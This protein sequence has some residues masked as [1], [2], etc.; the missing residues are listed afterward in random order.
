MSTRA[1][2]LG[3]INPNAIDNTIAILQSLNPDGS[4]NYNFEVNQITGAN[5]VNSSI[6]GDLKIQTASVTGRLLAAKSVSTAKFED[7][8]NIGEIF[9]WN[10]SQWTLTNETALTITE[11]DSIVGNEVVGPRAGG[12]LELFGAGLD[13]DPLTLDVL[14]GGIGNTELA[15]D[16]VTTDKIL[17]GTILTE[18]VANDAITTDK[19]LNGNVTNDKLDKN[20]IPL[21]GFAPATDNVDMGTTHR[22]INVAE[23][24]NPQDAATMNYVDLSI[25]NSEAADLDMDPENELSDITLNT[26]TLQLTNAAAGATGVDLNPTFATDSELATAITTSEAADNDKDDTN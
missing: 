10:G 3:Q 9:R 13:S 18:D 11:K 23:P 21:S 7:G 24:N 14:D 15:A 26:T 22:L 2:S 1:D 12:S 4:T 8:N 16:A 25:A 17:N 5:I 20:N 6:N 19:I